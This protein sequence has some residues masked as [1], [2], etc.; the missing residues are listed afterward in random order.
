MVSKFNLHPCGSLMLSISN[1][2]VSIVACF[3][4][5]ES[6][7]SSSSDMSFESSNQH[8]STPNSHGSHP[9][10]GKHSGNGNASP[11]N[12]LTLLLRNQYSPNNSA[13]SSSDFSGLQSF[14]SPDVS[15]EHLDHS[16]TSDTSRLSFSSQASVSYKYKDRKG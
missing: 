8:K 2:F 7:R 16:R 9:P 3:S 1:L 10:M 5:Q 11:A 14:R 15:F 12:T 4:S 13:S 6:Y